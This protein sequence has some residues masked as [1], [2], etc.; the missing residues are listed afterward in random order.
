M[1]RNNLNK[2]PSLVNHKAGQPIR[3]ATAAWNWHATIQ[4]LTSHRCS[5]LRSGSKHHSVI[6]FF[7][8]ELPPQMQVNMAAT[9]Q[10]AQRHETGPPAARWPPQPEAR[11]G[12]LFG[13]F[14]GPWDGMGLREWD[15]G[16]WRVVRAQTIIH[17]FFR[18]CRPTRWSRVMCMQRHGIHGAKKKGWGNRVALSNRHQLH[19]GL[20][21][22]QW[23]I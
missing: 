23:R 18:C 12:R 2:I 7:F 19:V 16:G 1:D 22:A 5:V 9:P 3:L 6:L 10:G 15:L 21:C 17:C 13:L 14:R 11:P 20:P 8:R 4:L